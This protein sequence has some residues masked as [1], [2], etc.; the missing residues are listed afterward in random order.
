MLNNI[1]MTNDKRSYAT[2]L[3]L[4]GCLFFIFG[5][6]TWLNGTLIPFLKTACELNN[7]Q[8][9]FVTFAFYISYF[10]MAI[11]SSAILKKTGFK[12]GMS[13]GLII[14]AV[15]C[16][17]FIPAAY[18]RNYTY[19]LIGL[20]TQ[21]LGLSILQT[22]TNPYVTILG[23]EE[24]AA[25]RISIMGIA[26]KVA[27]ILSPMIL[28]TVLLKNIDTV[29]D[30]LKAATDAAAKSALLN[31]L[32]QRI[33]N[34]YITLTVVLVVLALLI[35][36][37]PLPEL[38]EEEENP[39]A[40]PEQQDSI[41]KHTYLWL[42]ALAIF[43][44]VGVEVMAGDTII[45]YGKSLGFPMD[46]AKFFTSL[47]LTCM[48]VGYILGIILMPKIISQETALKLCAIIG[49]ILSIG[50]LVTSGFTSVVCLASLGLAHS[51]MWPAIWP[52]SLKGLGKFTKTGAALLIMG[53]AG[54]AI[55]PLLYGRLADITHPQTAY[56]IMVP[57]YLYILF[58]AMKGHLVGYKTP[59]KA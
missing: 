28:A 46:N 25:K 23:P 54:G 59:N 6:V 41:F 42:G 31:E 29:G 18:Q 27:G 40:I 58:F 11:P 9:Y 13:L 5:F 30:Q 35:L 45:N 24:S 21:G 49:I 26:N 3:F 56:I 48:V 37:S 39:D 33:V 36:I 12:R 7:F 47:T 16:V 19:F 38:H 52:M 55:L 57:V 44:Y 22:A 51:L 15:G 2:S 10:V 17:I 4:V 8:A 14:M 20:F 53:I 1:L 32:S 34:P 50:V 43:L